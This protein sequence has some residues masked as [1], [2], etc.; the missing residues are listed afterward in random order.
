MTLAEWL[1]PA[2]C[3]A[4]R[5]P[6]ARMGDAT[7]ELHGALDAHARREGVG[8]LNPERRT[9]QR[10]LLGS[11]TVVAWQEAKLAFMI[12]GDGA[13]SELPH[14]YA[15]YGTPGTAALITALRD[16]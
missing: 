11:P 16:L 9:I 3:P 8:Y 5:P 10:D 14:L 2:A 12:R 1:D 13:W 6:L 15:R 7:R 4:E